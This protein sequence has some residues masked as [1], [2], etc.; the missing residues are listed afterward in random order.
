MRVPTEI[1]DNLVVEEGAYA[2]DGGSTY[3]RVRDG[4]GTQHHIVLWQHLFTDNPDPNKLPGRLYF[5]GSPLAVRSDEERRL[6]RA[7]RAARQETPRTAAPS[8]KEPGPGMVV[9]KDL[10]DYH[11]KIAEGPA[12]ALAHLVDGVLDWVESEEYVELARMVGDP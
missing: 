2:S 8:K 11:A 9:G 7:L 3:L 4:E 12:A 5:D 6:V 1:P 10:Q